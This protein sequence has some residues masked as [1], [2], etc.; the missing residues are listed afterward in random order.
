MNATQEEVGD[1]IWK[2]FD[3][4][5]FGE[6]EFFTTLQAFSSWSKNPID[7]ILFNMRKKQSLIVYVWEIYGYEI[8]KT[9]KENELHMLSWTKDEGTGVWDFKEKKKPST[10]IWKD[11]CFVSKSLLDFT[12]TVGQKNFNTDFPKCLPVYHT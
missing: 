3:D 8:A 11:K 12:K 1:I 2:A 4:I 10:G 9:V 6:E 7:I 5:S